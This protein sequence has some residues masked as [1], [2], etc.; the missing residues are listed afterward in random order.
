MTSVCGWFTPRSWTRCRRDNAPALRARR[1]RPRRRASHPFPA[2]RPPLGLAPPSTLDQILA[3]SPRHPPHNRIPRRCTTTSP[4]QRLSALILL[5]C[6]PPPSHTPTTRI[7][8]PA[9]FRHD[10]ASIRNLHT[11]SASIS[12]TSTSICPA[13]AV[14]ASPASPS[15]S[16]RRTF[17]AMRRSPSSVRDPLIR[18]TRHPGV[19]LHHA[20][21]S[22]LHP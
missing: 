2:A 22:A 12:V 21:C 10:S 1:P 11:H 14:A 9:T 19:A 17:T 4:R 16:L 7:R 15:P 13:R 6:A 18:H 20:R 8:V 3:A 5:S